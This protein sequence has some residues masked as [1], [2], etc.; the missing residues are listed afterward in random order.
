MA[1][2]ARVTTKP[3]LPP[4]VLHQC[5]SLISLKLDSFS[6]L[7]WRS[8]MELLIQSLDTAHHLIEGSEPAKEITK[9]DEKA[10]PNPNYIRWAKNDGLLKAW[11]LRNVK[12]EVLISLEN[13]T[14]P[15]K[16]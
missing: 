15:Y 12:T 9:N 11:L 2:S 10:D 4:Q 5:S 6:Y 7:L 1:S 3:E 16:V 14:S 13:I 8:Q